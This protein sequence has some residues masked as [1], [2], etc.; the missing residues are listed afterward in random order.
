MDKE[1]ICLCVCVCVC[2]YNGILVSHTK[3]EMLPFATT[4]M[5]PEGIMLSEISHRRT[6][7]AWFH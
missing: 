4:D 1:F 5:E 2:M 7:T 3:N 6:N